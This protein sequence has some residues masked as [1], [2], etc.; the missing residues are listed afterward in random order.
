M[1]GVLILLVVLCGCGRSVTAPVDRVCWWSGA[2]DTLWARSVRT[3][4]R[5]PVGYVV[6]WC[7]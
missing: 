5:V 4:E 6:N 7:R 2:R 3:G 1:R